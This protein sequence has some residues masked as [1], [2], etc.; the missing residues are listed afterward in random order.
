M[1]VLVNDKEVVFP[2]SL[3]EI[4]LGQRIA[5]HE[6]YGKEL[7]LMAES[8]NAMPEGV[9]KDLE[10]MEFY[11][12]K[13]IRTFAFF[14]RATPQSIKDSKFIDDVMTIYHS[15]LAVLM[16]EEYTMAPKYSFVWNN[17]EW[18]IDAPELKHGSKMKFGELIDAKQA[19]KDMADL[20]QGRWEQMLK[21]CAIY[22]RKKGEPYKEEFLYEGSDRIELMKSLP[23]DIAIHV[24]FFLTT[25]INFYL[26]IS[27]YSKSQ[28][29]KEVAGSPSNILTATAG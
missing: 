24:G 22:L 16:E 2:S 3:S 8:I 18:V 5:F 4:T 6:Q 9:D 10:A 11:F 19:I 25:I 7:G 14:A 27:T 23:M 29:Q 13:A 12:E 20:G 17:E 1:R 21:M 15:C 26:N 28:G